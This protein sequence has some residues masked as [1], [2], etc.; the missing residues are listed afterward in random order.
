MKTKTIY[1]VWSEWSDG[2]DSYYETYDLAYEG[3]RKFFDD[4]EFLGSVEEDD[5]FE[6]FFEQEGL[7]GIHEVQLFTGGINNGNWL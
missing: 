5:T 6:V 7:I 2:Y 3:A 4:L 1:A